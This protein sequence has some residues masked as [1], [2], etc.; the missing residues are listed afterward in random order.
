MHLTRAHRKLSGTRGAAVAVALIDEARGTLR[1][2]GIGNVAGTLINNGETRGLV[3][4]NGTIGHQLRKVQALDYP[5][6]SQTTLVM[7]SDGLQ[8]RWT[9]QPYP[10]VLQRHPSILAAILHRDFTRGRDDATATVLRSVTLA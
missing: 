9:T 2:A 5:W 3:S 8:T 7:H 4:H 1:Y 10:G 6:A